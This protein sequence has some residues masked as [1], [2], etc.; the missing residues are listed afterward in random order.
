MNAPHARPVTLTV[1]VDGADLDEY[2]RLSA[3]Y[4]AAE[5]AQNWEA[6]GDIEDDMAMVG[7]RIADAVT[8]SAQEAPAG[9]HDHA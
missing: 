7:Q 1:T 6:T 4:D 9:G 2:R 5:A 8:E 3:A